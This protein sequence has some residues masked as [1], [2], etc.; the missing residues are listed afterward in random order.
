M[1]SREK[2]DVEEPGREEDGE[3]ATGNRSDE[4]TDLCDPN[5]GRAMCCFPSVG[6]MT[7]ILWRRGSPVFV[8]GPYWTM[9]VCVTLPLAVVGPLFVAIFWCARL[10]IAVQVT[11]GMLVAALALALASTAFRDPGLLRRHSAA[12]A[13]TWTWNDQARSFKPPG[14]RYCPWCDAIFE[15]FDHTCPWV[16]TAV[17]KRNLR[18]FKLFVALLQLL[19]YYTAAVFVLGAL[20]VAD[21]N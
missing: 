15:N 2:L 1:P 18:S 11:Y 6:N 19:A 7:V 9:L 21:R 16:G 13:S 12:P 10:H 4:P 20:H 17:A 8:V 14:A 3:F 5:L